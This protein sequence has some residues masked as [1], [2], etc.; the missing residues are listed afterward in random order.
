MM[1]QTVE[2][3]QRFDESMSRQVFIEQIIAIISLEKSFRSRCYTSDPDQKQVF[4]IIDYVQIRG[5]RSSTTRSPMC[6]VKHKD[7]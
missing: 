7:K 6:Q 4:E 1:G 2:I 5:E 3:L